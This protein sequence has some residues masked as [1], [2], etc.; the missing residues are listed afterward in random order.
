MSDKT[1]SPALLSPERLA[2]IRKPYAQWMLD[3]AGLHE[4]RYRSDST[5]TESLYGPAKL[6]AL[7]PKDLVAHVEA[8]RHFLAKRD[9]AMEQ[10]YAAFRQQV[11][12]ELAELLQ[13]KS[14]ND[15]VDDYANGHNEATEAN[16]DRLRA[17]ATRL[18]IEL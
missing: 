17:A 14:F 18:G 16:N 13:F 11:A 3:E 7:D 5:N 9:Y 10:A 1:E 12:A 8:Q 15:D 2:E 6:I 4:I